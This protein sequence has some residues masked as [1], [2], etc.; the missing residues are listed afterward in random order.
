MLIFRVHLQHAEAE[1]KSLGYDQGSSKEKARLG[2]TSPRAATS[3]KWRKADSSRAARGPQEKGEERGLVEQPAG[4][5]GAAGGAGD[6]AGSASPAASAS[7]RGEAPAPQ[8]GRG[9]R[10]TPEAALPSRAAAEPGARGEAGQAEAGRAGPPAAAF[11]EPVSEAAPLA[12]GGRRSPPIAGPGRA[13]QPSRARARG[14]SGERGE[15][16]GRRG[17]PGARSEGEPAERAWERRAKLAPLYQQVPL[18]RRPPALRG[19][20][21]PMP[22][23]A[24]RGP[25]AAGQRAMA[26]I[27]P[28]AFPPPRRRRD[29]AAV[30]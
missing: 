27:S 18:P 5:G 15:R 19:S 17:G 29:V 13:R 2:L 24:A 12:R 25:G 16:G 11:A 3:F 10:K 14:A 8:P 26:R 28:A 22:A 21:T 4:H 23:A 30:A 1:R 20:R 7:A 9:G 6:G